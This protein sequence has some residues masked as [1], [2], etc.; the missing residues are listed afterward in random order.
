[1]HLLLAAGTNSQALLPELVDA[2]LASGAGVSGV[3]PKI[4]LPDR[5]PIPVPSLIVK[6]GPEYCP[7]LS[8]NEFIALTAAKRSGIEISGFDLGAD[9]GLLVLD[10]FDIDAGGS[11]LGFEDIPSLLGMQVR[12]KLDERKYHGSYELIADLLRNQL[13]LPRPELEKFLSP[14]PLFHPGEKRRRPPEEHRRPVLQRDRHPSGPDVRRADHL[15]LQV[16]PLRHRRGDRGPHHGAEAAKGRQD[17]NVSVG[18]RASR[19][20]PSCMWS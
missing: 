12:N 11:R 1:M 19:L 7:G 9:G 5:A 17:K 15:D 4:A 3:Q 13:G 18:Q 16:H 20:R 2:Y 6:S 10:R 8:A 14:S